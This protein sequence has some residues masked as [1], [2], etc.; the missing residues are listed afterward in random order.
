MA[1]FIGL[2]IYISLVAVSDLGIML[3]LPGNAIMAMIL[4]MIKRIM[5]SAGNIINTR[6]EV[7]TSTN[8]HGVK[9]SGVMLVP[10]RMAIAVLAMPLLLMHLGDRDGAMKV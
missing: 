5:I 1:D 10:G 9:I 2:I 4:I 6:V 8:L 7:Q 3:Q